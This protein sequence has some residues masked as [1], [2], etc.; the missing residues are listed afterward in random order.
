[1]ASTSHSSSRGPPPRLTTFLRAHYRGKSGDNS[2]DTEC[3][4]AS[5][6]DEAYVARAKQMAEEEEG[7]RSETTKA[8][9]TSS[10]RQTA[11]KAR[12]N[13]DMALLRLS[14]LA[15]KTSMSSSLDDVDE[16]TRLALES[17]ADASM[18]LLRLENDLI[19]P[20]ELFE[21]PGDLYAAI[22]TY[23][24]I[25]WKLE[26]DLEDAIE[27]S[28]A[29]ELERKKVQAKMREN[30]REAVAIVKAQLGS[31]LSSSE[32]VQRW[33]YFWKSANA[34]RRRGGVNLSSTGGDSN[35]TMVEAGRKKEFYY[36]EDMYFVPPRF[37]GVN[38]FESSIQHHE[39]S[40]SGLESTIL[41]SM[42]RGL[43]S[44]NAFASVEL[45][46]SRTLHSTSWALGKESE[47]STS[48][49]V[50]QFSLGFDNNAK[51]SEKTIKIRM[52][53]RVGQIFAETSVDYVE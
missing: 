34:L 6:I 45:E 43:D 41:S 2:D 24:D 5:D 44:A 32:A 1:M 15:L 35:G 8:T 39:Q 38:E 25:D 36:G 18:Q 42:T 52:H 22:A 20:E 27:Y 11:I 26:T 47:V 4:Y 49:K 21:A 3:W 9:T 37:F 29:P 10:F 51:Y 12:K 28:N 40:S 7:N 19:S 14:N 30:E 50:Y 13:R 46:R 53:S 31:A 16:E 33:K 48:F 23:C 17:V